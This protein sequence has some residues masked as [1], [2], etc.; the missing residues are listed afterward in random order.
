MKHTR[1]Y[2]IYCD[3]R[4][5]CNSGVKYYENIKCEWKSFEDFYNDMFST[6]KNGLSIDRINSKGNYCKEN[7]R[8]ATEKQQANNRKSNIFYTYNKE[9]KT[10]KQW[11]ESFNVDYKKVWSRINRL[12]WSFEKALIN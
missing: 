3:V 8:W 1:F 12:K 11:T 10:L 2:T 4:N 5:R 9:T 7:C 6:Y